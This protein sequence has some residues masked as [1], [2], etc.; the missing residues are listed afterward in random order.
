MVQNSN[1]VN[2]IKI[3]Y[4]INPNLKIGDIVEIQ[5]PN[6]FI[7]G[8]FA[9]KKIE[10]IYINKLQQ[11][12]N[13]ILKNTD[14]ISTYIDLFRPLEQQESD[15]KADTIILSEFIEESFIEKHSIENYEG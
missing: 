1:I 3:Q 12:W 10:Y 13:I 5:R 14:L 9:V 2:E 4:D 6:Y 8:K 15:S 7:E 11:K